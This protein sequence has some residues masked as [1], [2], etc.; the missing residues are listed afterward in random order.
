MDMSNKRRGIKHQL[1]DVY[2]VTYYKAGTTLP[3]SMR[4]KKPIESG[5][6][7]CCGLGFLRENGLT[8]I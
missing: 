2:G 1:P 3:S 8:S 7:E 4:E 6:Q 5:F